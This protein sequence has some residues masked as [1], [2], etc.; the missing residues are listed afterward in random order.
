MSQDSDTRGEA[1]SKWSHIYYINLTPTG[2][3]KYLSNALHIYI[4]NYLMN[5]SDE[6]HRLAQ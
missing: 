6:I 5:N 3:R 4:T 2:V 1:Y